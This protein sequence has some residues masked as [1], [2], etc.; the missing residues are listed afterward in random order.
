[1][2]IG[3]MYESSVDRDVSLDEELIVVEA[4]AMVS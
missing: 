3:V 2:I 4:L 1:M